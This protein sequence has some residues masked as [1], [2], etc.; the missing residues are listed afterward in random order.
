MPRHSRKFLTLMPASAIARERKFTIG[1]TDWLRIENAY[2]RPLPEA[3]KRAVEDVTQDFVCWDMAEQ[4][5]KPIA[6]AMRLVETYKKAAGNFRRMLDTESESMS[7][8]EA[9]TAM[10]VQRLISRNFRSI[11]PRKGLGS[12][13]HLLQNVFIEFDWLVKE[14]SAN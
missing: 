10:F 2:G 8:V 6:D 14:R 5:A 11:D 4:E 9:D 1:K 13:F 7:D 12:P 3:V